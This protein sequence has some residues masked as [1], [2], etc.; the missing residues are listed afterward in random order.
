MRMNG[1]IDASSTVIFAKGEAKTDTSTVT[2][3]CIIR[4]LLYPDAV[5]TI[6]NAFSVAGAFAGG[7]NPRRTV[8]CSRGSM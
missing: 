3:F 8:R 1:V 7:I 5:T 4:P 6:S 2:E